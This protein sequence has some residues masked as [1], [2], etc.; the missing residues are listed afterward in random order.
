MKCGKICFIPMVCLILLLACCKDEQFRREWTTEKSPAIYRARFE[1]TKG[2]FEVKVIRKRSPLAADRFYQL[3]SHRYYDNAIF[4]RVVPEFVVQFGNTDTLIMA[5]W[6]SVPIPDEEVRYSNKRGTL[7]FARY[8]KTS[9]DLDVFINLAENTT[10][11]TINIEGLKGFPAFGDV[12]KGMDVVEKL[13]S[14]YAERPMSDPSL[15]LNRSQFYQAFPKLDLIE[16]AYLL[17]N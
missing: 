17:D 13:Y 5:Q 2:D 11:D 3:L 15:Y 6:R 16:N 1:T 4:Y 12:T 7:S 14:G 9:R 10:L 8:G